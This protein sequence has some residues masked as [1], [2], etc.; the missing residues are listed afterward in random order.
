MAVPKVDPETI[1]EAVLA[2]EATVIDDLRLPLPSDLKDISKAAS[3]VSGVVEDR[4]PELLNRVRSTTWDENGSLGAYEFRK[5]PI[6]FP[7]IL[8]VERQKPENFIF[9][10]EAKSWYILS[11]DPLTARFHTAE[12]VIS[13]GTLVVIVAWMLDSVVAGSPKFMRLYVDDA[14]RLA[15]ERDA[16]WEAIDAKHRVVQPTNPPGTPRSQFATQVR[17]EV[18]KNGRWVADADNFG[19]LDRL[20]DESITG[21][22]DDVLALEAAGKSLAHWRKFIKG[23]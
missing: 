4:I 7:D 3:L 22:R 10:I 2:L 12:S 21:F 15:R 18:E 19:K 16:R 17:A 5:Y 1:R 11:A 14:Q 23:S 8:L 6:G 13:P 20:Y 9:E